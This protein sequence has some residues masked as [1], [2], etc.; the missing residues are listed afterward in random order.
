M[1]AEHTLVKLKVKDNKSFQRIV[2]TAL[3][4]EWK[5]DVDILWDSRICC[6]RNYSEQGETTIIS[7]EGILISKVI[8]SL[9]LKL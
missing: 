6:A 1:I 8:S 7:C 4:L 2:T 9:N 3:I 5:Q